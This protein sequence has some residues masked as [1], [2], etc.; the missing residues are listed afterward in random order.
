MAERS[1][2]GC[3]SGL[4]TDRVK[5]PA[6]G[7]RRAEIRSRILSPTGVRPRGAM[8][9]QRFAPWGCYGLVLVPL[10]AA[11]SFRKH[12]HAT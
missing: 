11:F 7:D 3:S 8:P 6:A 5:V 12:R 4:P 2:T 1:K 10:S 9:V